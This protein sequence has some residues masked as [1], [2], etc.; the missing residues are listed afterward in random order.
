MLRRQQHR[1]FILCDQVEDSKN[2]LVGSVI[3]GLAL[4]ERLLRGSCRPRRRNAGPGLPLQ[5]VK[6]S[7]TGDAQCYKDF[8]GSGNILVFAPLA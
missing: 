8:P 5:Y 1:R 2:N 3:L 7:W 6:D 4:L